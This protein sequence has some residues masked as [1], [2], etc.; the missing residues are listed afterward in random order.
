M[1]CQLVAGAMAMAKA[2]LPCEIRMQ[3]KLTR[4][5]GPNSL[6]CVPVATHVASRHSLELYLGYRGVRE[7]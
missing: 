3:S 6:N 7:F 1:T 5:L 2:L 4:M